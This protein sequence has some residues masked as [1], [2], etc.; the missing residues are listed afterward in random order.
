ML[1]DRKVLAIQHLAE[2]EKAKTEIAKLVGVS[3]V[4]LYD[5]L[6]NEEFKAE[7]DRRIQ[8]RKSL[9]ENIIDS[10]LEDMVGQLATL[11]TTSKNDMVKAKIL[12]Y[13]VDRG[14]GKPTSKLEVEAT[15]QI[16]PTIDDDLLESAYDDADIIEHQPSSEDTHE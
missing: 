15:N 9:V 14:L 1:D 10:K 3:R 7:L 11:A 16:N 13:W 6:D 8:Q 5:W 2:G 12:T 4:T